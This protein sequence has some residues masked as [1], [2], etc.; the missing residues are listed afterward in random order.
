MYFY[1]KYYLSLRHIKSTRLSM[2]SFRNTKNT[3]A[4]KNGGVAIA[5]IEDRLH[6]GDWTIQII[7]EKPRSTAGVF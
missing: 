4:T 6:S 7:F 5:M 2:F 1:Y 3:W